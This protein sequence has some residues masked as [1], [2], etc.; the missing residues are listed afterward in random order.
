MQYLISLNVMAWHKDGF[1]E[2]IA[3]SMLA[4][5]VV[6][7]DYSRQLE[8]FY[9]EETVLFDLEQLGK[10]PKLLQQLLEDEKS[11][12]RIAASAQEKARKTATW[13]ARAKE[14]LE[15]IEKESRNR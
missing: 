8:E 15:I 2:R 7:S 14:L 6:V 10:L 11:L 3:D 9:E 5:A 13:D 4:G 1:T 12:Q